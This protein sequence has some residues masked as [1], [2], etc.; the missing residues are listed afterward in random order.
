MKMK[1]GEEVADRDE[2]G[3][4]KGAF[5]RAASRLG[6]ARSES[7]LTLLELMTTVGVMLVVLTAAALLLDST[8]TNLNRI[9]FGGQASEG[10]RGALAAFQ[11]DVD[12]AVG[13]TLGVSPVIVAQP[14]TVTFYAADASGTPEAVT[15][16]TDDVNHLLLRAVTDGGVTATTTV[17]SGLADDASKTMF[18]YA[19]DASQ[20]WEPAGSVTPSTV[21]LV[22][23]RLINTM[24]PVATQTIIDRSVWCRVDVYAMNTMAQ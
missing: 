5:A 20:G 3:I 7:G 9:E 13:T 15:W 22:G 19:V 18:T 2:R 1:G 17:L 12:Q 4:T 21:G 14:R 8:G 16:T 24:G 6:S 10:N 23:M 11:R